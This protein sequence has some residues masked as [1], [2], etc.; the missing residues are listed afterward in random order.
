[1]YILLQ[2][3]GLYLTGGSV[4]FLT[5]ICVRIY[6]YKRSGRDEPDPETVNRLQHGTFVYFDGGVNFFMRIGL[7]GKT[8]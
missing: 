4:L 8:I 6:M 2:I 7:I 3:L 1:M 5:Y